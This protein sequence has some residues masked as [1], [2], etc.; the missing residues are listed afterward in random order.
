MEQEQ[1]PQLPQEDEQPPS[2]ED[3]KMVVVGDK[4]DQ[5]PVVDDENK[6]KVDEPVTLAQDELGDQPPDPQQM[7]YY[8]HVLSRRENNGLVYAWFVF[9]HL[10]FFLDFLFIY[11]LV[12]IYFFIL[13]HLTF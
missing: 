9:S 7:K 3:Q 2:A 4:D 8:D 11:L 13:A 6:E 5:N 1:K 12:P 10:F